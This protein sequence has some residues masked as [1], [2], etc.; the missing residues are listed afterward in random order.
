MRL[1]APAP[2]HRLLAACALAFA[3][4]AA[5]PDAFA[6]TP[7]VAWNFNETSGPAVGAGSA[8]F[9]LAF[10]NGATRAPG[11]TGGASDFAAD[12]GID[13]S[14]KLYASPTDSAALNNL[15]TLTVSGWLKIRP[16]ARS[17]Y[18]PETEVYRRYSGNAG[19][20]LSIDPVRSSDFIIRYGNSGSG[21]LTSLQTDRIGDHIR[22]YENGW[23]FFAVTFDGTTARFYAATSHGGDFALVGTKS[24][25][26]TAFTTPSGANFELGTALSGLMDNIRFHGAV[27]TESQVRALYDADRVGVVPPT[28]TPAELA[29]PRMGNIGAYGVSTRGDTVPGV[30]LPTGS[31]YPSPTT[32]NGYPSGYSDAQG[33]KGL[34]QLNISGTGGDGKYGYFRMIPLKG[35]ASSIKTIP[36]DIDYGKNNER[37][38]PDSYSVVLG[39]GN[40]GIGDEFKIEVSPTHHGAKYRLTSRTTSA[41]LS[42]VLLDA[43]Y[44]I[45][46]FVIEWNPERQRGA[47]AGE[48]TLDPA[49]RTMSGWGTYR[50]GWLG[51]VAGRP[52]WDNSGVTDATVYFAARFSKAP[53]GHGTFLDP[54]PVLDGTPGRRTLVP[55]RQ[56]RIL[57]YK[58]FPEVDNFTN[59]G[60]SS[61]ASGVVFTATGANPSAWSANASASTLNEVWTSGTLVVGKRYRIYARNGSDSFTNVGASANTAGTEFVA[62]ATTPSAWSSGS[63]LGLAPWSNAILP[64]ATSVPASSVAVGDRFGGY[65]SFN[66][67]P[68]EEIILDIA[69]SFT[70]VAQA[71]SYLDAQLAG[72]TYEQVRADARAAWDAALNKIQVQG[73][74]DTQRRIFYSGLYRALKPV[75]DRTDDHPG[76]TPGVP[77]YDDHYAT[78]DTWRTV[79]PLHALINPDFQRDNLRSFLNRWEN[80]HA[81]GKPLADQ[82]IADAFVGA[83]SGLRWASRQKQ[84]GDGPDMILVDSLLKGVSGVDYSAVLTALRHSA[85]VD[86]GNREMMGDDDVAPP[87]TDGMQDPPDFRWDN[88]RPANGGAMSQMLEY[89]LNDYGLALSERVLGTPSNQAAY[90]Q[91]S[92]FWEN[93]FNYDQNAAGRWTASYAGGDG[94]TYK[95]FIVSRNYDKSSASFTGWNNSSTPPIPAFNA[96]G[97]GLTGPAQNGFYEANAGTYALFV[98]HDQKGLIWLTR[99]SDSD[100]FA[101]RQATFASR[102]EQ[103]VKFDFLHPAPDDF[104]RLVNV[105][106]EPAF[107][108]L[109]QFIYA[110]RPDLASHWIRRV[111]DEE[112]DLRGFP[113]DEDT[114]AM[115][116]MYVWSAL[117]LF[118]NAGSDIYLLNGPAFTQSTLQVVGGTLTITGANA[119]PANV[120]VQS[121]TLNGQP[122]TR[123]WLRHAEIVN[124]GTLA[125]VMGP[126]PSTWGQ[127]E[128]PPMGR[129]FADWSDIYPAHTNSTADPDADGL[130]NFAEYALASHPG[131]AT[132]ADAPVQGNVNVSGTS[133]KTI[134]FNP[135]VAAIS[136]NYVVEVSPDGTTWSSG[137]SATTVVRTGSPVIVRDN[138]PFSGSRRIRLRLTDGT[139][140]T[141]LEPAASGFI[142]TVNAG[143]GG[144]I[145][146]PATVV[147]LQADA[148]APGTVF[149]T[150]TGDTSGVANLTAPLTTLTMPAADTTLTATFKP[151]THRTATISSGTGTTT[152]APGYSVTITA[153]AP[154][155]GQ[156]FDQWTGSVADLALLADPT[157]TSQTFLMPDRPVALTAGYVSLPTYALTVNSGSGSGNYLAGASVAIAANTPPGNQLFDTWTGDTSH[158]ANPASASTT[159]TAMPAFGISVTATYKD[160]PSDILPGLVGRWEFDE[161]TG[162]TSADT[163]DNNNSVTAAA[164]AT[165]PGW[166]S[167]AKLGAAALSFNGTTAAQAASSSALNVTSG[168]TI[169]VWV[170]PS[171]WSSGDRFL[172]F[173]GR[174]GWQHVWRL[175]KTGSGQMSLWIRSLNSGAGGEVTAALPALNQWTHV[176]GSYDAATGVSKLYYNGVQQASVTFTPTAIGTANEALRIGTGEGSGAYIGSLDSLRIY[177]RALSAADVATVAAWTPAPP[178]PTTP[179]APTSLTAAANSASQITLAWTDASANET[180]FKV[181]RSPDGTTGWTEIATP[182]ANAT[183]YVDTGLAASTAYHYRVRATNANGDSA[184]TAVATATTQAAPTLPAAPTGLTAT[185]NSA[186]QIT[187]AWTDASTN[188][189]GFKVE[190]SP[191]GTTGW[192]EIATP[193]ANATGYVNT[194]L[195]PSTAYHY[196]VRATNA[197]GDSAYTSVAT[198]TTQANTPPPVGNLLAYDGFITAN[199]GGTGWTGNWSGSYTL[200]TESLDTGNGLLTSGGRSIGGIYYNSNPGGEPTRTVAAMPTTGVVW[201]S[202]LQSTTAA[203]GEFHTVRF[204]SAGTDRFI[205][206]HH[207]NSAT[208]KL[209]SGGLYEGLT[210]TGVALSGT[211]FVVVRV[212]LSSKAIDLWVNPTGLGSGSAPSSATAASVAPGGAFTFD[213]IY[214][215]SSTGS[216]SVDEFRVGTTWADVSP[217]ATPPTGVATFRTTQGLAADGSQDALTP[218]GDGIA[219]LLKYAFNLIGSGAGQ[220]PTLATPNASVLAPDGSAGLPFVEMEDTTGELQ[221]TY[222]RRKASSAPGITYTV[223]FSSTLAADSWAENPSATESVTSLNPTFERVTVTDSL[224]SPARRFVRV[225]VTAN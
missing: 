170:N 104:S 134:S 156:R 151:G 145:V 69:V 14:S 175:G 166:T 207:D 133:Y 172:V 63:V 22:L 43:G 130:N 216:W 35:P 192:T 210:E 194:G 141:L 167:T 126:A 127:S 93:Y 119:S 179:A 98:P 189:T 57:E 199:D 152:L 115:G 149:D 87:K 214:T 131:V 140:T 15:S 183:G 72:K 56:Y 121:A 18:D 92:R 45:P 64:G 197:V 150:W 146:A 143:S 223:E 158:L 108:V 157:A 68:N 5:A 178:A 95:G 76:F 73:G 184:Y 9:N 84:G 185:A 85:T 49:A 78:W 196:R 23:V 153:A 16:R 91:R 219:N 103:M 132:P 142:L 66:T 224:A 112:Y 105:G 96:A 47:Q 120:Y 204:R 77:L 181:E 97:T 147:A 168:L 33:L 163:S 137:P 191:N 161:N 186:T 125:F 206:G 19:F 59:V 222:I 198:A 79:F 34:T 195:A 38:A 25:A 129:T 80:L 221:L 217:V 213:T 88:G 203:D 118:P 21:G 165:F 114:G 155:V 36:N 71:E 190:R 39:H 82:A 201:I 50:G 44:S 159:V 123:A 2:L 136:V 7:L 220:S 62:T 70:S 116:S 205:V 111:M 1:P 106:N 90:A 110:G 46:N 113:G 20:G 4:P 99:N 65:F 162:T 11:L 218:A 29:D 164:D 17:H 101:Q 117:G 208:F 81:P 10:Q 37:L 74:T 83:K 187:L 31:S 124:G 225:R 100:T 102:I 188:E 3:A 122:L 128:P 32:N 41:D 54:N 27:L 148:P 67:S 28:F 193:A 8:P 138:T 6:Q 26:A 160:P 12:L 61:N 24:A 94:Q 48:F 13:L 86:D 174:W 52:R 51:S 209:Y 212:D 40:A 55:G 200:G 135:S 42:H 53:V 173:K 171:N 75:S 89:Q 177:N 58:D 215:V 30:R 109:R 154:P 60:A 169:S 182:A 107:L 180:G 139:R 211:H 176:T 202:W 144:G